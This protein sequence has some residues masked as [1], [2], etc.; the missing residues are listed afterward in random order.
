MSLPGRE[1]HLPRLETAVESS[2]RVARGLGDF[3]EGGLQ[4]LPFQVASIQTDAAERATTALTNVADALASLAIRA[5]YPDEAT[6]PRFDDSQLRSANNRALVGLGSRLCGYATN[7]KDRVRA[8]RVDDLCVEL[9]APCEFDELNP[10]AVP[11]LRQ[12]SRNA[13]RI[14]AS[15]IWWGASAHVRAARIDTITRCAVLTV[16]ELKD[17]DS[18]FFA[19]HRSFQ[20]AAAV[21]PRTGAFYSHGATRHAP[22][23]HHGRS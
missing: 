23:G 20:L 13:S 7:P 18:H 10:K 17:D 9:L 5:H 6:R 3:F 8:G 16:L 22:S 21:I 2:P 4:Y 15:E 14:Q 1:Y 19:R 11:A 12:S